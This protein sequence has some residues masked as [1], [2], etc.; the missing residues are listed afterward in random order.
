MGWAQ[1]DFVRSDFVRVR[2]C[3]RTYV[4]VCLRVRVCVCVC[5]I[6]EWVHVHVGTCMMYSNQVNTREIFCGLILFVR[7]QSH[8]LT[9]ITAQRQKA[10]RALTLVFL[11]FSN[12]YSA[13][14]MHY[15]Y[16]HVAASICKSELFNLICLV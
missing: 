9:T 8:F 4:C 6:C 3:V 16:D 12:E 10:G 14:K 13:E 2:A 7:P 5:E 15:V 1:S 11:F